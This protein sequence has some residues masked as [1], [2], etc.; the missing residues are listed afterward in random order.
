MQFCQAL[1]SPLGSSGLSIA[2][3]CP[4]SG[5]NDLASSLFSLGHRADVGCPEEGVALGQ[6]ALEAEAHLDLTPCSKSFLEGGHGHIS[7]ST[8]P[9]D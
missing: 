4:V 5:Q 7:M 8:F 3:Q 9:P 1:A 6:A 2:H